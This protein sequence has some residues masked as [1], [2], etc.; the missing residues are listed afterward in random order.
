VKYGF[1]GRV[2]LG[3]RGKAGSI[4]LPAKV[5]VVDGTKSTLKTEKIRIVVNVPAG[6]TAGYF[7]EVHNLE[8]SLPPGKSPQSYR[9]YVGFD[10][11]AAGT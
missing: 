3:P 2:L 1:T 4:S 11:G 9:I 7:S 5:T 10:H 6:E 8:L